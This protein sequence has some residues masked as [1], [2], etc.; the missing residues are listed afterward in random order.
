MVCFETPSFC[1]GSF[2]NKP[3]KRPKQNRNTSSFGLF[4]FESKQKIVSV[5][6]HTMSMSMSAPLPAHYIK[7]YFPLVS[8]CFEM[9]I[10]C[11][12]SF[13][14]GS[15][16]PKQT[17]KLFFSFAKQTETELK[18]INFRFVSVQTET[19]NCLFRG[20]PICNC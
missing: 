2:R 7:E 3:R 8:V 13:R 11:F 14:N 1:F 9:P 4:R 20:H 19:K 12:G 6:V 5:R 15:K 16:T 18:Q 10:Y 17:E